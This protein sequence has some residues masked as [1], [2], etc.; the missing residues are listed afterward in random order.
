ML[1]LLSLVIVYQIYFYIRYIRK[2]G[3]LTSS[4]TYQNSEQTDPLPGVSVVVCARNEQ[5]NLKEYLHTLLNQSY[6]RFEVIVVN[7]LRMTHN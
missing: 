6:P 7:D 2:G 4:C 3:I 1:V 5:N